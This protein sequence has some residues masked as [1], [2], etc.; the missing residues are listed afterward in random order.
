VLVQHTIRLS[1]LHHVATELRHYAVRWFDGSLSGVVR[2]LHLSDELL[3]VDV[4]V[5]MP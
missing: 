2:L 1:L 4:S 5:E 3:L